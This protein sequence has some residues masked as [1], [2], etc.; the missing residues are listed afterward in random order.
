MMFKR[1]FI[2][3]GLLVVLGLVITGIVGQRLT[4]LPLE[5]IEVVDEAVADPK[6][7]QA[8]GSLA[9]GEEVPVLG[10]VD[11]KHYIAY[12][13]PLTNGK[14]GY[15]LVGRFELKRHSV[16]SLSAHQKSSLVFS[17]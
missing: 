12:K 4:L 5:T 10:C 13:V 11:L 15:V 1:L 3:L 17:C 2:G 14:V 6:R 16:W 7:Y 9:Q 8:V